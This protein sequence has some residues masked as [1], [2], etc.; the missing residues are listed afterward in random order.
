MI[1]IRNTKHVVLG[2]VS[3]FGICTSISCISTSQGQPKADSDKRV[4]WKVYPKSDN[5]YY[6]LPRPELTTSLATPQA[7]N[8]LSDEQARGM[9]AKLNANLQFKVEVENEGGTRMV[10][11]APEPLTE[12]IIEICKAPN[13]HPFLQARCKKELAWAAKGERP[14]IYLKFEDCEAVVTANA[15][16][17]LY[18]RPAVPQTLCPA[19]P[20]VEK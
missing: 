18:G 16:N 11:V 19:L 14:D 6:I 2:V 3:C 1:Q 13:V 12:D 7:M 9:A 4:Y 15:L 8:A 5:T 10:R 17:K 20:Q